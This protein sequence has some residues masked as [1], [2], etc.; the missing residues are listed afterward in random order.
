MIRDRLAKIFLKDFCKQPL[1]RLPLAGR[2][3][4]IRPSV[5]SSRLIPASQH[6]DKGISK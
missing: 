3:D 6:D 4:N 2:E 5:A 1:C